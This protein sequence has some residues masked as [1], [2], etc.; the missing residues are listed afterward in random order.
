MPELVFFYKHILQKKQKKNRNPN[1][2]KR[3]PGLC[4]PTTNEA[5]VEFATIY[6]QSEDTERK[7]IFQE[8]GEVEGR[9]GLLLGCW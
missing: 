8:A 9:C 2:V 5:S 4:L 7:P 6:G 1:K 3:L